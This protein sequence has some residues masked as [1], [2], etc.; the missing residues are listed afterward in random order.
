MTV[1]ELIAELQR[2]SD[3]DREKDILCSVIGT[4]RGDYTQWW[5]SSNVKVE[6]DK[7]RKWVQIRG[8]E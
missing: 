5:Q 2:L 1:N 7:L 3:T 4:D 6:V 8:E